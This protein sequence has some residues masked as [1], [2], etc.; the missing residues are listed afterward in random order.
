MFSGVFI[1]EEVDGVGDKGS[2]DTTMVHLQ[3][4]LEA[5]LKMS[6]GSACYIDEASFWYK[7]ELPVLEI[8]SLKA[9]LTGLSNYQMSNK[10]ILL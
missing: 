1:A 3:T 2:E 5:F 6:L 7:A 10:G 4:I 8:L 9:V